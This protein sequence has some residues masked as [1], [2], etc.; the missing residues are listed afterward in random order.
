MI[1]QPSDGQPNEY[2]FGLTLQPVN[3]SYSLMI[4]LCH[5]ADLDILSLLHCLLFAFLLKDF[6]CLLGYIVS[7]LT[8]NNLT[9]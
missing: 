9:R 8:M 3:R 7:A 6:N 2:R 1:L 5:N 4:S